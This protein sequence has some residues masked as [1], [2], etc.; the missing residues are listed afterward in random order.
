MTKTEAA[1]KHP[2]VAEVEELSHLAHLSLIANTRLKWMTIVDN[3]A[4]HDDDDVE[5]FFPN[6]PWNFKHQINC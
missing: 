6:F 1:D 2:C 5:L 3:G 4:D